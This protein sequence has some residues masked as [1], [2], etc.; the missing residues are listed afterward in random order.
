MSSA[1]TS[2]EKQMRQGAAL[3]EFPIALFI[4]HNH[5]AVTNSSCPCFKLDSTATK[6][7]AWTE[8]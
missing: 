1:P 6:H 7:G 5:V 2:A 3:T 4:V 8:P